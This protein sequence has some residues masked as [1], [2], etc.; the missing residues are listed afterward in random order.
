MSITDSLTDFTGTL[1]II[2]HDKGFMENIG[3]EKYYKIE[4]KGL[5]ENL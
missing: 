2:S 4:E 3:I 1:I 5:K